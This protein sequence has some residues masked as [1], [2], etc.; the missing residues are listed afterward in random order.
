MKMT[1]PTFNVLRFFSTTTGIFNVSFIRSH[2]EDVFRQVARTFPTQGN[3]HWHEQAEEGPEMV[4]RDQAAISGGAEEVR[5]EIRTL[6]L[7]EPP[8]CLWW[9]APAAVFQV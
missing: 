3:T 8:G 5:M 4:Q 9:P 6:M 2:K 7:V 1:S